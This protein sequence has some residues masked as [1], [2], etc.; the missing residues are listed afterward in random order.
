[1]T[2]LAILATAFLLGMV[3]GITPDE[4]TWPITF[5]YAVGSYSWK[6]GIR[7]GLLF[8]L[9]FTVQRSIMCEI[10]YFFMNS[11][12]RVLNAGWFN[13]AI[14]I[15]VGA[16]MTG[17][18]IF[19]LRRG[20]IWHLFHTHN[21][22]HSEG[23]ADPQSA[24]WWMPL[25]HGFI[26]GWGTGAFAILVYTALAP[27]M[28]NAWVA[29]LPGLF[30]GLGTMLMQMLVGGLFGQWMAK[31]KLNE[32][33]R[34]YLA[35][36]MSGRVLAWGGIGFTF[37]GMSGLI[38]PAIGDY[39]ISTGIKIHNLDQLG[40][41]FFLA[42][43]LLFSVAAISFILSMKE[44]AALGDRAPAPETGDGHDL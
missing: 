16:V 31:Q 11:V 40:L 44:V 20:R 29:F 43:I 10:A 42:V 23:G 35:R 37:V 7:A 6:G 12:M 13:F 36:L 3:H 18:G 39:Q 4:H 33:A 5:S 38:F 26:A 41:G 19:I 2:T 1:M 34:I 9:A 32:N 28:P 22:A 25:I 21:M 15:V 30:F 8:S 27:R 17:S 24:P 14:Y